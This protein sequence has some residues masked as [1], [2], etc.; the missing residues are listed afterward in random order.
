MNRG[1]I[2][3]IFRK[4]LVA[5]SRDRFYVFIT[6][7]G[8]VAFVAM[9]WL[10]PS[11]VDET[12]R[13]GVYQSGLEDVL[14]P[15]TSANTAALEV[16]SF[17]APEELTAAVS[18]GTG[19]II[20]GISFPPDF[21]DS[22]VAGDG[23][24]ELLVPA[25][26]PPEYLPLMEGLASQ[27]AYFA[28]GERPPV[29]V[30]TRTVVLGVDRVGD[31]VSL[32]EQMRPLLAFFV[33]LMETFALASLVSTEVQLRTVT[34]VLVT[35]ARPRDF[36]AAKALLGTFLALIEV[37][38]LMAL[39]R[40]F[41]G[42]VPVLVVALV[43]GSVLVTGVGLLA[44]ASGRDFMGVMFLSLALMIPLMIPAFGALFPGTAATW[45]KILPTYGLVEAIVGV[46]TRGESWAELGPVLVGLGLWCVALLALGTGILRRRVETL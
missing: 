40:G 34:A 1:V 18:E 15:V 6:I 20:A 29:D 11:N 25:D 3:A 45:V 5:F 31:Q 41:V 13:L 46:T 9:Y 43:L 36:L 35:P 44:G 21:A 22:V 7:L 24:V 4:D 32:Q 12:I 8:L 37:V 17:G 42:D 28:A 14:A 2:A 19:G 27:V 39:I 16:T 10:L 23:V 38:L 30:A 26:V 33:L